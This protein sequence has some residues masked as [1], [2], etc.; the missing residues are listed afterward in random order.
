MAMIEDR[1]PMNIFIN[2]MLN[3][4]D[5]M[6]IGFFQKIL[7]ITV[8]VVQG[9]S[10]SN[11]QNYK[12]E[13]QEII[14]SLTKELKPIRTREQLLQTA[15]KIKKLFNKLTT[16]LVKAKEYQL[17]DQ[18]IENDLEDSEALTDERMFSDQLKEEL[19]RIYRLDGGKEII[20]TCQK[21]A[22]ERLDQFEQ[23][24]RKNKTNIINKSI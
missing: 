11:Q 3:S 24:I 10:P 22:L 1:L 6:K 19:N 8:L 12:V 13:G 16:V 15:P 9:C 2:H 14:R 7:I 23:K 4:F 18:K 17:R 20:E 21:D 5:I